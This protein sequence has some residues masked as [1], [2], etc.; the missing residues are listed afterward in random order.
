[1]Q[2]IR[3]VL[4][5]A[6]RRL[7]VVGII[8]RLVWTLT[9]AIAGLVLF[10]MAD[11]VLGAGLTSGTTGAALGLLA[12]VGL[13]AVGAAA[14]VGVVWALIARQRESAVARIVDERAGLRESLS[15]A[16]CVEREQDAWSRAVVDSAQEKARRVVVRDAIP[17]EGP[18]AWPMPTA[19]AALLILTFFL[20]PTLDLRG[21]QA[22]ARAA[23]EAREELKIAEQDAREAEQ[24]MREIM[25]KAGLAPEGE[26]PDPEL[27]ADL[28]KP[29][30]PEEIRKESMRQ[31]TNL[32][33]QLQK[34]LAG[35][36][37][38]QLEAMKDMMRRLTTP[39]QGELTEFSRELSRGNFDKARQELEKLAEKLASGE[40]S[41]EQKEQL[42]KQMESM[43]EQLQQL[44]Q[45]Q[46][47][48]Q[49]M[50]QQAG[51][52]PE[53]AK[54]AAAS[55]QGMQQALQQSQSLTP[56]QKQQLQQAAQAMQ[57]ASSQ[58][59][60]MGQAMSQMA[61][62]MS[63]NGQPGQQGMD[64]MN[65]QLTA[66]EMMQSQ[67]Q[68]ASDAMGQCQSQMAKL[69]ECMGGQGWGQCSGQGPGMTGQWQSGSS[70]SQGSGSGG[71]G[72]G[73]GEGPDSQATDFMLQRE[74]AK[75]DNKGGAIIGSTYV[76]GEQIKGEAAAEFGAAI[77]VAG[78]QANEEILN[79][80]VDPQFRA[81]VKH[82]YGR[83]EE[84]V[85]AEQAKD[86]GGSGGGDSGG[87]GSGGSSG[88]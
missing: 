79:M 77:E 88:G 73:N 38:K 76:F 30:T 71:P 12:K 25:Q 42:A 24:K 47:S 44:A 16:L 53:Q 62:G 3:R 35:E 61:A 37:A 65:G 6:A 34:K 14:V 5:A 72:R 64:S 60:G 59:Q 33:D 81:A 52:T 46:D 56:E 69:G 29:K 31:L 4:Q 1:M 23:A 86:S 7:L 63:Q 83:L 45:Q 19:A 80:N 21:K 18:R 75:V 9:L 68:T 78:E 22:E 43:G 55:A 36:E 48:L 70:M 87:D 11:R 2:D 85:K 57:Q 40:L 41:P 50:L 54:Q 32:S 26:K 15:T 67:M 74:Q 49:Q 39:G 66:M 20:M 51:M 8:E 58:C 28:A 10:V 13:A 17:I 82:Y 84:R 27:E